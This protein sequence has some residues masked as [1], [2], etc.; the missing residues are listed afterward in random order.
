M[1]KFNF[2][3]ELE[4]GTV[5]TSGQQSFEPTEDIHAKKFQEIPLSHLL[6]SLPSVVSYTTLTLASGGSSISLPR[7]DLFDARFQLL[8][9]DDSAQPDLL[10][11]FDAPSDLVPGVYEGGLKTWEC[12]LD[13][14]S[15]L[16]RNT[17]YPD[18]LVGRRIIEI[19]CGTAVPSLYVLYKLFRSPS[20]AGQETYL[21]LQDYNSSVLELITFPNIL[22]TWCTEFHSP[23][24][25]FQGYRNS[26]PATG[27]T[28]DNNMEITRELKSAFL[29]SLDDYQ[30]RIRFFSGSWASFDAEQTGGVYHLVLSS[31]TIYQRESLYSLLRLLEHCTGR[32]DQSVCLVAAKIIYFGVG[33]G[34][35]EFLAALEHKAQV[36]TVWEQL[37]GVARRIMRVRWR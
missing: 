32:G 30:L 37:S 24:I 10:D 33:G 23:I 9:A 27:D 5:P 8:S 35:S 21:H 19:G 6:D 16:E 3:V 2:N 18:G 14:A 13:L 29:S 7:R 15:Y 28:D 20:H 1:F 11:H 22:L 4:N 12:S 26:L 31:E 17:P 25:R 36:E 34:V